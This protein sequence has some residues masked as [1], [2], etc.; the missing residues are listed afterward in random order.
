MV[1]DLLNQYHKTIFFG[2]LL[3]RKAMKKDRYSDK[4]N[5]IK[6]ERLKE[7]RDELITRKIIKSKTEFAESING[8]IANPGVI[9]A[10][11]I[12]GERNITE[13]AVDKICNVY[14]EY[15]REYLLGI[16]DFKTHFEYIA[17]QIENK[18]ETLNTLKRCIFD[19]IK[20]NGIYFRPSQQI[21][22]E[23]LDLINNLEADPFDQSEVLDFISNN[24][25]WF[26]KDER[27]VRLSFSDLEKLSLKI[28]DYVG[29]EMDHLMTQSPEDTENIEVI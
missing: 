23:Q 11:Y 25:Y 6:R 10:R 21:S 2:K 14:K 7:I 18:N 3:R 15:R 28:C 29:F 16:D 5:Q 24:G 26:Q 1:N 19:L 9:I 12:S 22:Q 17:Y 4:I 8:D 27:S 20:L 13:K